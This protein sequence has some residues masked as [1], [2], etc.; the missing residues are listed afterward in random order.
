MSEQQVAILTLRK[1]TEQNDLNHLSDHLNLRKVSF[2]YL[3]LSNQNKI[4]DSL[5]F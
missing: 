5:F 3:M 1:G 4:S 2:I